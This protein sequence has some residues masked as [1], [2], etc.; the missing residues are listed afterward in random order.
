MYQC[1]TIAPTQSHYMREKVFARDTHKGQY[2]RDGLYE[3]GYV[4]ARIILH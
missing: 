4:R 3:Q 2:I 1:D